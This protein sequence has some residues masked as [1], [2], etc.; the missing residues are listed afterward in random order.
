[1]PAQ[2]FCGVRKSQI[3]TSASNSAYAEMVICRAS[4]TFGSAGSVQTGLLPL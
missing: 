4:G 2:G 3:S 1:M